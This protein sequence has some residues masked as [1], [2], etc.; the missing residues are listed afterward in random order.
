MTGAKSS[1]G[2]W[3]AAGIVL[4]AGLAL[5]V[6]SVRGTP[7]AIHRIER[8]LADLQELTNLRLA[9][10]GAEEA[11]RALD[12]RSARELPALGDILRDTLPGVTAEIRQAEAAPA[13]AGW[14]VRRADVVF[15]NVALEG[16]GQFLYNAETH[17][18]PWRL[19]ECHIAASSQAGTGGRLTLVME[20]L[21]E[22]GLST[23]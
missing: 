5:T 18:P 12:A 3:I 20:G 15:S 22:T 10:S 9:A 16:I 21:E 23:D 19:V 4:L 11:L 6:Q 17:E 14:V 1:R 8:K 2:L 13:R 7:A